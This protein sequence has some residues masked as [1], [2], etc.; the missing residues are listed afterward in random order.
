VT[1]ADV[2]A[3]WVDAHGP[4]DDEKAAAFLVRPEV[5]ELR[6]LDRAVVVEAIAVSPKLATALAAA[7]DVV[8]QAPSRPVDMHDT[9]HH[10][11]SEPAPS[12]PIAPPAAASEAINGFL[13]LER[14]GTERHRG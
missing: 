1:P 12:A 2:R 14:L 13:E 9:A 4:L 7:I 3:I 8:S 11:A 5:D 6:R 10:I